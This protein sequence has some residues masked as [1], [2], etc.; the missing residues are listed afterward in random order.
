MDLSKLNL[1]LQPGTFK[2]ETLETIRLSL[3]RGEWVTSLDFS[4]AYFHIP[5]NQQSQ[6]YLRFFL[7]KDTYQFTALP[8]GLA[9]AP[10]EFTKVVKEVKLMAYARFIRI[11]Q[12][13]DDWLLRAPV[14]G[15][16]PTTY[17]DPLGPLP[18]VGLGGKHEEIGTDSSTGF[19]FRRLPV[20]PVDRS[21]LAHSGKV[22]HPTTK[23]RLHQGPELLHSQTIRVFDRTPYNN[24]ETGMVR[25]PSH[26]THT[27][28]PETTLAYAQELG[29][30]HTVV[31]LS[32][33]THRL[34]VK[35][36]KCSVGPTI[37]S[38]STRCTNV[39][40]RVKQR[41]GRTLRGLH[42]KRRLVR[43]RKSPP[44]QLSRV[45][46]SFCGPQEFRASL[47]GPDCSD[48]NGQH[49]CGLLHQQGGRY[50]I[51]LFVCPHLETPVLVSPQRHSSEGST[52]SRSLECNSRPAVQTQPG[53]TDQVVPIL[54]G[55]QS[56]MFQMGP[57]TCRPVCKL[58]QSQTPQV[59]F[60]GTGSN[61]LCSGHS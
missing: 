32:L 20:R 39:Y 31:P 7:G 34:V 54:A 60:T 55:V 9:T 3:R 13:I 42:C 26:E 48:S 8:F 49:N 16:L 24:R 59:C 41:L 29:K 37:A 57:A 14:P 21:G 23:T 2:M 11:H 10:L 6:K 56:H 30:D 18:R 50:E 43:H 25:S 33:S 17:P 28:A 47:Q 52:H 53:D 40:R 22:G 38:P 45:K 44:H 27:V 58:V 51:R 46:S 19:Q 1:F 61:S 15:N 5:I 35:R 36:E 12:Y 4:D